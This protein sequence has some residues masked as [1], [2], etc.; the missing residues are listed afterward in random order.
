M[1]VHG[2]G[3]WGLAGLLLWAVQASASEPLAGVWTLDGE[4]TVQRL[5]AAVDENASMELQAQA[6]F[7]ASLLGDIRQTIIL[8]P[9]GAAGVE[10]IM[11]AERE[12]AGGTW[13]RVGAGISVTLTD[14][15]GASETMSFTPSGRHLAFT[16]QDWGLPVPLLFTRE[17]DAPP[18]EAAEAEPAP[19]APAE[20]W[21]MP[22]ECPPPAVLPP[23]AEG[24]P[25]D[26]ILGLRPGMGFVEVRDR[27][28][29]RGST[30]H[31]ETAA[32]WNVRQN[33]GL[34][35]RQLLRATN[36]EPC[37]TQAA[38]CDDGGRFTPRRDLTEE[39]VVL[40][41]GM[42]EAERA[43]AIWRR[44]RFP[45][46]ASP[47]VASLVEA[48]SEK[49]GAPHFQETESG[50][51]NTSPRRGSTTLSWVYD[52]RNRAVPREQAA[53]FRRNCLN[54]PK[55]YFA[56]RH[57]WNGGCGLT[58]RAEILPVPGSEL[59]ASGLDVVV[60]HQSALMQGTRAFEAE[61]AAAYEAQVRERGAEAAPEL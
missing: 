13:E 26:D 42:P 25:V 16:P 57:S 10:M 61:L 2:M 9:D 35:T 32:L 45:A 37:T 27:I 43:H 28:L 5:E 39:I 8:Q 48:L 49:Y 15:T 6:A 20:R 41:T 1:R 44:T 47:S 18:P 3:V 50:M 40:F 38:D 58:V 22:A 31:L 60:F 54:G 53:G 30:P 21:P 36:G 17:G 4:A 19:E 34:S 7:V 23:R 12:S 11:G 56:T 46:E 24:A 33:Y 55:P 14:A 51:Y 29:C 59:V 52:P